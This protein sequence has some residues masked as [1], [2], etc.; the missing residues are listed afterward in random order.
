[1]ANRAILCPHCRRLIGSEETVCSWC[2]TS[3]AN[4]WWKALAWTRGSLGNNW[5]VQTII[6]ANVV[7]YIFSLILTRNHSFTLNPLGLLSPGQTSLLLLGATGTV[8]IDEYGRY[9]SLLSANYLHGG[10]LH[11]AFNLMAFRQIAPWVSQEYGAS[12]M[13][14]IYTIGGVGGYI[15]SYLA[16]VPFTIGASAAICALIGSLLYFGKAR[17]GTYGTMVYREVSG[18][19]I[20]LVLF[21]FIVPGINNWAHGGGILSGILLGMLLGYGEQR[22]ETQMH[23]TIGIACGVATVAC[24]AFAAVG[25]AAFRL[26]H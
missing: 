19:V 11:I 6:I 14:T 23:R 24:L 20:S 13:F 12:R 2:G 5:P 18:W 3:R 21:G 15:V 16:G 17:G 10:L 4:P 22:R 26:A 7:F 8:P 9:W 1:M 25:S